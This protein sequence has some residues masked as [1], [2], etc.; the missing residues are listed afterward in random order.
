MDIRVNPLWGGVPVSTESSPWDMHFGV[1]NTNVTS[2]LSLE[3][4]RICKEINRIITLIEKKPFITEDDKAAIVIARIWEKLIDLLWSEYMIFLNHKVSDSISDDPMDIPA[5]FMKDFVME[6]QDGNNPEFDIEK[7]YQNF[8]GITGFQQLSKLYINKSHLDSA[9]YIEIMAFIEKTLHRLNHI[10]LDWYNKTQKDKLKETISTLESKNIKLKKQTLTDTL[11]GIPNRFAMEEY[12]RWL[13]LQESKIGIIA[14]DID[15]FKDI[16][17]NYG[18]NVWDAILIKLAEVIKN[19]SREFL[20]LKDTEEDIVFRTGWEEFFVFFPCE[21]ED[22]AHIFAEFIRTSVIDA[23]LAQFIDN[24]DK[25]TLVSISVWYLMLDKWGYKYAD[26]LK[27]AIKRADAA[28]YI[29]KRNWRNC[30]VEGT[31]QILVDARFEQAKI[32]KENPKIQAS[33]KK[34]AIHKRIFRN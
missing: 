20:K 5:R 15:R 2:F 31:Q 28:M 12:M 21:I 4:K 23:D 29:A 17:D 13:I 3:R 6:I 14:L 22:D 27:E 30:S 32:T 7:T 16:N 1:W 26:R 34:L 10:F 25:E 19:K 11:T 18:H 33:H 24:A 9:E 8:I